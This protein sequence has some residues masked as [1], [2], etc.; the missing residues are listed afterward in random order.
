MRGSLEVGRVLHEAAAGP[1]RHE[2]VP[3]EVAQ[4]PAGG[5]HPAPRRHRSRMRSSR[6]PD[7]RTQSPPMTQTVKDAW[8]FPHAVQ[9]R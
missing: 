4:G 5:G 1:E 8:V 2:R 9:R 6:T 3:V 7:S